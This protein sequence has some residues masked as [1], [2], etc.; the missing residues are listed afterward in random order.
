MAGKPQPPQAKA[1]AA[2]DPL[3]V[4]L[5]SAARVVVDASLAIDAIAGEPAR[6]ARA[7][8]FLVIC[9]AG[10]VALL[11]PP[12]FPSEADT[13]IRRIVAR[14]QWPAADM[15][16]LFGA[17]D[18]LPLDVALDATELEAVRQRARQI[19][20]ELALVPVYDSTYAALA[21]A[22]G[23]EFWTADEKFANAAKQVRRQ[24]NG[25]TAPTLPNV[26]FIGDF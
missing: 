19:A 21:E 8:R 14:G 9:N 10:G 22:R 20:A 16:I 4:A 6:K 3:A 1:P 17:L 15:P 24:P 11:V 25:T 5:Q 13:A 12:T 26:R 18:A 23:C 2:P 7:L